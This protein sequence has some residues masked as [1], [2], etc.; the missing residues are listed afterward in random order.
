MAKKK[1]AAKKKKGA[2]RAKGRK[3]PAKKKGRSASKSKARKGAVKRKAAK[4][5][6]VKKKTAKKKAAKKK[7]KKKTAKKKAAKKK[8]KKKKAAKKKA[9]KKK[10]KKKAAKK[11]AAK[12]KAPKKK[13]VKQAAKKASKPKAA[14]AAPTGGKKKHIPDIN[15]P[16]GMY[17]GVVLTDSPKPFPRSSP[18]SRKELK[19]L[20]DAL[21]SERNRLRKE[22]ATL[23][24]MSLGSGGGEK[25]SRGFPTHLADFAA[26]V[27]TTQTILGV[28]TMEKERLEQV[29]EALQRMSGRKHYGLC[30]ACGE[31][32]GIERL[33]AKPH[34]HLCMDCR[35]RYERNR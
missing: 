19:I 5:K 4:K 14:K 7:P 27:E 35:R 17:G 3:S 25:E 26:D 6:A 34:A 1:K 16:T 30:L 23:E 9:T 12:K 29:Q 24:G 8:T 13:A 21:T 15:R 20:R 18:Y 32:V 31:K 22:L 11:K 10:P 28:Q 2:K 33:I